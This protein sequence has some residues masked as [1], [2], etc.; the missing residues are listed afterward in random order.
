MI[1]PIQPYFAF[2]ADKYY[3]RPLAGHGIA[4][5]YEYT[6]DFTNDNTTVAVPDGCVDVM[7]DTTDGRLSARAAGTVLKGTRIP[8]EQGHTYFGIRFAP[9]VVPAFIDG[10]FE[11]LIDEN[12]DLDACSKD[13]D[14]AEEIREKATF[15]ERADFFCNYYR[16][17][18]CSSQNE[19]TRT[20]QKNLFSAVRNKIEESGGR[21]RITDLEEFTGYTARYIDRIFHT[22]VGMSPKTFAKIV[23]FQNAIDHL[24]HDNRITFSDLAADHGY[25]DQPQF[26]RDFRK[27]AGTTP[28]E[29]RKKIIATDYTEKFVV[30]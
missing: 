11:D 5:I 3:K 17:F 2:C 25:Y 23:R 14:L 12:V 6:C 24:D 16:G 26:I 15:Q 30:E 13:P 10:S 21:I 4:H 27:Y 19:T 28:K 1:H 18:L 7:F 9:G 20:G 22:Y 29:Y 8:V